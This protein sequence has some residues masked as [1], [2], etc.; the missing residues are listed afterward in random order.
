M[1][2]LF[3][4]LFEEVED[5]FEDFWEHVLRRQ[6][7]EPVKERRAVINGVA[8]AVRPAYIFAE[9][10]DNLLRIIFGLSILVSAITA[11]FLGFSTLS[12]LLGI[13]IF[14]WWGR[15]VMFAIG[16]SYFVIGIW[17]LMHIGHKL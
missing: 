13:L 11:S 12:D 6:P 14:T 17:K 9:R 3:E 10:V 2:E 5:F 7:K 4:E 16:L 1:G 8:V 15:I